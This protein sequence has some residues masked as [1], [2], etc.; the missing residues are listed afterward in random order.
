[1]KPIADREKYLEPVK[2]SHHSKVGHLFN[3][4]YKESWH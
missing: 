3:V 1:M 2:F 4:A